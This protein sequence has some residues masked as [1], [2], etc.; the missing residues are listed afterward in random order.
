MSP[1]EALNNLDNVVA[2]YKGNRQE[3][4]LLLQS[5]QLLFDTINSPPEDNS[6]KA[7][8]PKSK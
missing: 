4:S 6:K 8:V 1:L 7:S 5:Y 3:H 2:Q